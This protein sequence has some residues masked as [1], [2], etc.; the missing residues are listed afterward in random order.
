MWLQEQQRATE[1][2]QER[3]VVPSG[4]GERRIATCRGKLGLRSVVLEIDGDEAEEQLE[5][6]RQAV[7]D[8]GEL[9]RGRLECVGVGQRQVRRVH[10]EDG[11]WAAI[12]EVQRVVG[13]GFV[14]RVDLLDGGQSAHGRTLCVRRRMGWSFQANGGRTSYQRLSGR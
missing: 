9:L 13:D 14:A 12:A 1:V 11:A 7:E 10:F 3:R 5:C 4:G 6:E 2:A 8:D